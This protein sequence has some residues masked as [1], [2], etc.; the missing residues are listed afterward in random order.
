MRRVPKLLL[1]HSAGKTAAGPE[2]A[3]AIIKRASRGFPAVAVS[4]NEIDEWSKASP[5]GRDLPPSGALMVCETNAIR[6]DLDPDLQLIVKAKGEDAAGPSSPDAVVEACDKKF[7]PGPD[8][9]SFAFD[10]WT[11]PREATAIIMAGGDSVRMGRDKA[12]M[13]ID[14]EPMISRIARQLKPSFQ[15]L[16]ISAARADAFAFLGIDVVPD[17]APG[18][19]PLMA[20]VSALEKSETEL[21]FVMP[22]D[23][24][25]P[26]QH[27]IARLLREAKDADVVVPANEKGELEPLFAV[28]RKSV[29]P[30][31][32]EALNMGARRV[33]SFYPKHVVK[34]MP[35]YPGT[36]LLNLN[37]P[38]DYQARVKR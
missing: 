19:G 36:V 26:P 17:E 16:F 27:L 11:F 34:R 23:I 32:R 24:P 3:S 13:E 28:Y 37:T 5:G 10:H 30:A 4:L 1:I 12:L 18:A 33:I 29:L 7:S 15:N 35:M 38:L 6:P 9:F 31:A 20:L 21:N 22:C 14:G 2:F 25:D 8:D